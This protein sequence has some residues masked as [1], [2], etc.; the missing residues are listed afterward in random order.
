MRNKNIQNENLQVVFLKAGEIWLQSIIFGKYYQLIGE[1]KI[2]FNV[3][4]VRKVNKMMKE[5]LN[6]NRNS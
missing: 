1:E 5:F 3:A 4:V 6:I 2:N